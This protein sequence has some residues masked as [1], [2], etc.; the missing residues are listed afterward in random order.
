MSRNTHNESFDVVIVG[1]GPVGKM[2]G[3]LLGRAGHSVLLVDRKAEDYPLPRA[4]GHDAE[5]ARLMQ[6][7]GLPVDGMPDAVEA[8]DDLYVW[9]NAADE[10]L[11]EIDVS[12]VSTSGWGNM[13]FYNQPTLEGRIASA[14]A[15]LPN[16]QI[17]R[18]LTARVADQHD[19]GVTIAIEPMDGGPETTVRARYVL[20]ADG[21]N[22]ATR[23]DAGIEWH[24]LGYFF[25]WLVV[26]VIPGD[27]FDV[28]HLAKQ[29]CDPVRPTTVV[30]S[31]PGR[32][33]W[34]FMLLEGEDA[35]ELERPEKIRELLAPFGVNP[36]N[37]QFERGVVYTFAAGWAEKWRADRIFLVGDAAHLMPPFAAQGL[38]SGF[39]DVLNL[40]W[41]LDL[42][43]RGLAEDS[44][45]DSY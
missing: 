21:A 22:S 18:G 42:V 37:A 44:L 43:L 41:K 33:R 9:V 13:Y 10:V 39:R 31:G 17:R 26:D 34:E 7:A 24:D 15:G 19:E 1:A 25:D 35:K 23:I 3:L 40:S 45:L 11:Q 8:Y 12:G 16:V 2:A 32:R 27:G 14:L 29:I 28:T 6:R 36:G 38:A 20:G 5:I 30:P 4:V